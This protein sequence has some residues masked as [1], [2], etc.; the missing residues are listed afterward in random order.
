MRIPADAGLNIQLAGEAFG[1]SQSGF[2]YE[3]KLGAENTQIADWLIRLTSNQRNWGAVFLV[4]AQREGLSLEPQAGVPDHRQLELNLR[5]K[6]RKR[7]VCERPQ[8]LTVPDGRNQVW[9]MDF[10]HDQLGDWRTFRLFNVIDD[11]NREGLGIEVDFSLP[12][13]RVI[14]SL[15]QIMAWRGKPAVLRCDNGPEYVSAALQGW[16]SRR[17]ICIEYIQSGQPQ[18]NAHVERSKRTV[19][20]EWLAQ[21]LFDSLDEVQQ[22]ATRWLWTYN[23]ERPNMALGGIIPM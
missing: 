22:F 18:Q 4:S 15:E 3:P 10:M 2:H 12:S 9:S 11:F 14:L 23:H 7:M 16:A 5:I 21:Y 17:G 6:P 8:P 13:G 1:L 19:C 20:Y